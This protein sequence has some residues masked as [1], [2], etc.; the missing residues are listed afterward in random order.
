MANRLVELALE[1]LEYRKTQIESEIKELRS[2]I[3]RGINAWSAGTG[4]RR[5]KPGR[6]SGTRRKHVRT[7][8]SRRAQSLRMKEY[9]AKRRAESASGK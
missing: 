8:A 3:R 7:A 6:R 1:A 2:Q 5:R 4:A 9:W